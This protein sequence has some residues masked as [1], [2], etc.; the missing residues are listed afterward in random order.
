MSRRSSLALADSSGDR[1]PPLRERL[2]REVLA[3]IAR[4]AEEVFAEEGL[5]DAHVDKIAKRAGVAVGTLYNYYKDR[6]ALLAALLHERGDALAVALDRSMKATSGEPTRGRLLAFV[7]VYFAFFE[8]HRKFFKILLE[9]ELVHLQSIY[10]R[11]AAIPT[12]CFGNLR[13]HIEDLV[14]QGILAGELRAERRRHLPVALPRH[15]QGTD[16]ARPPRVQGVRSG[17]RGSARRG[18][19]LRGRERS[20]DGRRAPVAVRSRPPRR[21]FRR[22]A[23]STS[24]WS[25]SRSPSAR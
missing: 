24:G 6:D 14:A 18:L 23:P 13:A 10:P 1:V 21:R 11:A 22:G 19:S 12:G 5:R 17:R 9:G 3:T 25:P 7:A 4:A 20:R 15:A 8:S 16:H 2:R